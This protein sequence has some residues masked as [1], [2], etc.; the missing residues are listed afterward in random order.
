MN[1][2]KYVP[3]FSFLLLLAFIVIS[4]HFSFLY[5]SVT[6]KPNSV[7]KLS[8]NHNL[9]S[10]S[11]YCPE[12]FRWIHEDIWPWK[13][14]GGI[15]RKFVERSEKFADLKLIILKGKVYVKKFS[16]TF[17]TRDVF[18]VWG[19]L[20]LL[21]LYPGQVP[22][23]EL[24][25]NFADRPDDEALNATWAPPVFY[26]SKG[27]YEVGILF[28]DWTFWGWAEVNV[29]PWES[30]VES[31]VEANKKLKWKDREPYAFWRGNPSVNYLRPSLM[32]C[33]VSQKYDWNARLY[34][35]EWD[36]E[37]KQGYKNSNIADQ[38]THRYKIY[39]EGWGWSV[40][41]K[42]IL[43][44]DSMALFIKPKFYDFFSRSL[45]P[46][47]HFWPISRAQNKCRDIKFAVDWGNKHP[48]EVRVARY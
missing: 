25:F 11:L 13:S 43:A 41:E 14:G 17:Q 19:I 16:V 28:P 20:Q 44:C 8:E 9:S 33:N 38:C 35:Q 40:S 7:T 29:K 30:M 21:R 6:V 46:M 34:A 31:I 22:D 10:E 32:M 15:D 48:D 24:L 27:E 1:S 47:Q 5:F 42:Y 39:I 4:L 37:A 45:L 26:Y 23:V 18:T 12:H 3:S 36:K 2:R